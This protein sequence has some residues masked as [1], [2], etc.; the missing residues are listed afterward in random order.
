[1]KNL[2]LILDG[3]NSSDYADE[4]LANKF[5]IVNYAEAMGEI[6]S[7]G[8]VVKIQSVGTKW[9]DD[10]KYGNGEW[11]RMRSEVISALESE[12]Q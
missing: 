11:G 6:I 1:M 12:E 7:D 10:Q 8:E 5:S 9:R 3:I 4:T 2:F